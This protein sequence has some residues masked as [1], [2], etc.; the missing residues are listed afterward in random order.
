MC[1]KQGFTL[2]ELM[3]VVAIIALVAAIA[4]PSLSAYLARGQIDSCYKEMVLQQAVIES[5]LVTTGNDATGLTL[6]DLDM[7]NNACSGAVTIANNN[8]NGVIDLVAV[9]AVGGVDAT[10]T[11][12]RD[13]QGY[14]WRCQVEDLNNA[15]TLPEGCDAV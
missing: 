12:G 1:N 3:I 13:A 9:Q 15:D 4:V 14:I 7:E 8:A 11:V 6:A 5:L 10:L 2:V